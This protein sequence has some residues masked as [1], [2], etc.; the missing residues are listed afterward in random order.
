MSKKFNPPIKID[1]IYGRDDLYSLYAFH[2]NSQ[3]DTSVSNS[4]EEYNDSKG[5]MSFIFKCE[6]TDEAIAKEIIRRKEWNENHIN[7]L[8]A[9][10]LYGTSYTVSIHTEHNPTFDTPINPIPSEYPL[11]SYKMIFL[12]LS[13]E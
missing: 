4:I 12:D 5:W 2:G 11:S 7:E 3:G 13:T 9:N 10:G 6:L 1:Y 8:K